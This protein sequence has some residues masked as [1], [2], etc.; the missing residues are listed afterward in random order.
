M[1]I[2]HRIPLD[3]IVHDQRIQ[4]EVRLKDLVIAVLEWGMW[5]TSPCFRLIRNHVL[6]RTRH[7]VAR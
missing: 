1:I 7:H 2:L 3:L 6:I 4:Q 5:R